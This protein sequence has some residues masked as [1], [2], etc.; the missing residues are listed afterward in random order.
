VRPFLRDKRDTP[1]SYGITPQEE[2]QRCWGLYGKDW[3]PRCIGQRWLTVCENHDFTF[4]VDRAYE[5]QLA[6]VLEASLAHPISVPDAPQTFGVYALYWMGVSVYV[7]QARNLR[8]RLRDHLRKIQGRRGI[9][10]E[11]VAC[12]YLTFARLWEVA[13]AEEVLITRFEPEWNGIPGFSMHA[14]GRGR[15]GMPNYVNQ[16]D[17]R[18]PVLN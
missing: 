18:F 2:A 4:D 5:D 16:W 6:A 10:T 17:Q 15:P 3:I 12:K 1:M 11:D 8:N 9:D 7:G 13:R 14:P